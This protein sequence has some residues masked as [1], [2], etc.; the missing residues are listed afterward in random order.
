LKD[1]MKIGG[2]KISNKS[3]G[4]RSK[5]RLEKIYLQTRTFK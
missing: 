2:D 4:P 1:T 3:K 5:R